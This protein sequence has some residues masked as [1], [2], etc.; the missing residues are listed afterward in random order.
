MAQTGFCGFYL[1]VLAGGSL[2]PGDSFKLAA[3]KRQTSIHSLFKAS[4]MKTRYD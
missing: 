2:T 1:S 3:G 4:M